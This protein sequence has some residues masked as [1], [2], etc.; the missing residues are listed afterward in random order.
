MK[1]RRSITI[2]M[3]V[4][5][6]MVL[7][8]HAADPVPSDSSKTMAMFQPILK[9]EVL[10]TNHTRYLVKDI[11]GH[12]ARLQVNK[13]R[14]LDLTL[15]PPDITAVVPFVPKVANISAFPWAERPLDAGQASET[16]I[17][18]ELRYL[19]DTLRHTADRRDLEI[20]ALSREWAIGRDEELIQRQRKFVQKLRVVAEAAEARARKIESDAAQ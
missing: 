8:S 15:E 12:E 11:T 10:G 14:E 4:S 1:F 19:A 17:G 2:A 20:E 5:L 6:G 9:E 7:L 18:S 3:V 13:T 16:D